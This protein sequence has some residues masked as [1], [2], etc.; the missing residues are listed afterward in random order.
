MSNLEIS[1]NE[2]REYID[3][4]LNTGEFVWNKSFSRI[5]K[6][7]KAGGLDA[8]GYRCIKIKNKSYKAHR[9]A[10]LYVL[11]QMPEQVDHQDHDRSNNKWMNLRPAT[12]KDNG[13]NQSLKSSNTSGFT[14]V[15]FDKQR[16]K[17][18]ARITVN[19]KRISLG[20]FKD[21][22]KA[23]QARINAKKEYGFHKNHGE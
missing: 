1:R 23:I 15:V 2:L 4:N 7:M 10:F 19:G 14:G 18:Q 3:Y 5:K 21:K 17:W 22:S 8:K 11:G 16:Q 9:L 13:R 6:G 12:H 20:H